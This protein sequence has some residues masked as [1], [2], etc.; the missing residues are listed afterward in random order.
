MDIQI[1]KA[2][3]N[4]LKD[5]SVNIPIG[6]ITGITGVSG[7]GK[8][9]L[10][11]D[12]IAAYGARRF[13]NTSTKT[14][15]D[16]INISD[17]IAV[18]DIQHLPQTMFI[19]VKSSVNNPMSTVST[20]SG[21][22][23]TL[24]NLFV[25][26]GTTT[27]P[28]CASHIGFN[29]EAGTIFEANLEI[30]ELFA[31]AYDYIQTLGTI[32]EEYYFDK[33]QKPTKSKKSRAFST[34][35]FVMYRP[36]RSL[37]QSFN[38]QFRCR[39]NIFL[40]DRNH[41]FDA[42]REV[43]CKHCRAILPSLSRSRVSFNTSYYEG[44]GACRV[45]SGSGKTIEIDYRRLIIDE[46]KGILD[47]A[48]S[49]VS[50]KGIKYTTITE[51]FILAVLAKMG[52]NGKT[53]LSELSEDDRR[54]L[55]LG[56][57]EIIKFTDR[58]GGKKE[59]SFEGIANYLKQAFEQGK[60]TKTL[61][62]LMDE[63][64]CKNCNESRID[65]LI[66]TFKYHGKTLSNL[67]MMTI[68]Q[69]YSF[70]SCLDDIKS[71]E[72]TYLSR[73]LRKLGNYIRVSC[74]HLALN[75]SSNTLS[76][77]ELQ[78]I[79]LCSL[80][81]SN[82]TQVCY[83]LDEPS[84]GLHYQDI[85]NLGQLLRD[86]CT[87][88]NS[89]I[90]VEHNAKL[91]GYCEYIVDM[92][93]KGGAEGGNVLIQD[94]IGA[95]E[96][97]NTVTAEALTGRLQEEAD[98]FSEIETSRYIS[99]SNVCVN[100]LKSISVEIPIG[101]FTTICG[102]SGSGKSTFV[103][104]VVKQT[105]KNPSEYGF[106]AI[107]FI[108]QA[109]SLNA[110]TSTVG[111]MLKLNDYI[112]KTYEKETGISKNCFL[113]GKSD[114]KCSVCNG[115]GVILSEAK[116]FLGIC[117]QCQG[118]GYGEQTLAATWNGMNI[119]EIFNIPF[120][121]LK[122]RISDK[123]IRQI[124]E[125][126]E[127][128][129]VGYLSLAR[130]AKTLS[131]GEL[132]RVALIGVLADKTRDRLIVLDEPSKGMH[133]ADTIKLLKAVRLVVENKN[134]V[135][136]VEHNPTMIKHSDYM[137]E[138]GGTG[139]TGGYLIFNGKPSDIG[140]T[141]TGKMIKANQVL[142]VEDKGRIVNIS[143]PREFVFETEKATLRFAP[144]SVYYLEEESQIVLDIA[145]RA[146]EDFLSVA[147][148]NNIFFSKSKADA[149]KGNVPLMKIV[150]FSEKTYL[151]VSVG[152]A[153]GIATI[154]SEL[155]SK[156]GAILSRYVFDESSP[157]G[158]CGN[159]GGKGYVFS[160][161][162][163]FFVSGNELSAACKRF[164]KNSTDFVAHKKHLKKKCGIDLDKNI[165]SMTT[166]ESNVLWWGYAE[167]FEV[168][169]KFS[170]WDGIIPTFLRQHK[171]YPDELSTIIFKEKTQQPCP[172]C[173]GNCLEENYEK[174]QALGLSYK[175]WHSLMISELFDFI[176]SI[177]THSLSERKLLSI[178]QALMDCGLE[179]IQI[180]NSLQQLSPSAVGKIKVISELFNGTY[181]S[182]IVIANLECLQ[183]SEQEWSRSAFDMLSE[184]CTVWVLKGGELH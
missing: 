152:K 72:S 18:E 181:G 54:I 168:D 79:R 83:L 64:E 105:T 122:S 30:N 17:H 91:L 102:I 167:Y 78:R 84:S 156:E 128:L 65:P 28:F 13:T 87:N 6:T 90:M 137:L 31:Q 111:T 22:H 143:N 184:H 44:G 101:K 16:A 37:V 126:G 33:D 24:R 27:C 89:I 74:G 124:A 158:K 147:I 140:D 110:A 151:N 43:A 3:E 4:N 23:E 148:P 164:L 145:R 118:K 34:L 116:E 131:K 85:E 142:P 121:E 41:S 97:Y 49:F 130:A 86:L 93:P 66:D 107:E 46:R 183:S 1:I 47:G 80:L 77:G 154:L 67:L 103:K 171:Y 166:I 63:S 92:G 161:P 153:L 117:G 26:F 127:L 182:G 39:L 76:G 115:K 42:L 146:T 14:I 139:T 179:N 180:T 56:S 104:Y 9:T 62:P 129:G 157:T 12:V 160:V 120:T 21:I 5:I 170:K 48:I 172:V 61:L 81:N 177:E 176:K 68:D 136:A 134:T 35:R 144:H 165:E 109:R 7:S 96:K 58:I 135:I 162:K 55:F 138:F 40:E 173:N 163:D 15:K 112:A 119:F 11:R 106:D 59:L 36:N 149:I 38:K 20:I 169:G 70:L 71:G 2:H 141:P 73:L 88:G 50:D 150:D 69:L 60:G 57:S 29:Y 51:K 45:C 99:F 8:S 75:R 82:V 174:M 114:G 125:F 98:A 52:K 133:I 108:G 10:L 100:N 113:P 132:Q 25:E 175:Q 178:L 159:C 94:R 32:C 19:D 155:A 95:L 53:A 123:K